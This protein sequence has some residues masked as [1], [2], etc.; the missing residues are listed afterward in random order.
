MDL[1]NYLEKHNLSVYLFAN[2]CRLS[3]PVIYR[4]LND[5]NISPRSAKRIRTITNG[6][7][8]YKNIMSFN[9]TGDKNAKT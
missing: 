4:I 9:S 3:V 5:H 6:F 8:D 7:V 2:I 1:K